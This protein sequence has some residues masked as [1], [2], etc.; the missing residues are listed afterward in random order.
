[1]KILKYYQTNNGKEPCK[2]WL[3]GLRDVVG[4]TQINK[5]L[6]RLMLGQRGDSE[7]VGEGVFELKIHY[8][9][10]YRLY[11]AEQGNELVVL[12]YGGSKGSQQH[13]ID[14]AISYWKDYLEKYHGKSRH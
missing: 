1:M 4:I 6:E 13:D 7:S 8:G 5:R 14:R 10:G 2:E 9:L 11:Y 3:L 12:L